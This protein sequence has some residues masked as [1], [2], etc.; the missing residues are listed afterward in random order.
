MRAG[1]Y[2]KLEDL[3]KIHKGYISTKGLMQGGISNHQVA[4]LVLEG[5]LEKICHGYYWMAQCG[6]QKPMD[7]KCIEVCLSDPRAVVA[8]DSAWYYQGIGKAE[9]DP[10]IVATERTDR[11]AIKMNF[12]IERHYFSSSLFPVGIRRVQT[13]YGGYNIYSVERSLCDRIRLSSKAAA[14]E[15]E[16]ELFNSIKASREQYKRLQEYAVLFRLENFLTD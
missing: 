8:M 9:P 5:Y 4:V 7:Y 16:I 12:A 1:T 3:Y 13:E 6:Y 11:S 15:G 10:M 2:R 14:G